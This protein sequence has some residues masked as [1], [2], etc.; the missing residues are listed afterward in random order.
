MDA[1]RPGLRS[2]RDELARRVVERR[3]APGELPELYTAAADGWLSERFNEAVGGKPGGYALVAVGGYGRGELCP[4]SDLDLVLLHQRKRHVKEVADK[5]WYAVWDTGIRL[6]HSVRTPKESLSV[7][8]EDQRALLGLLDARV[9]AGDAGVA[10]PLLGELATWW[11]VHA[12]ELLPELAA[13]GRARHERTGELPFLLEP[14]LKETAGGLR[15]L[16]ALAL[17]ARAVPAIADIVLPAELK[18]HKDLILGARVALHSLTGGTN[19]RLSLQEQDDVAPLLGYASADDLMA[20]LSA[21]G[22]ETMWA[23][24][25]AWRHVESFIAGPLGRAGGRDLPVAEGI[26]LRDDTVALAGPD[27]SR[28]IKNGLR[29]VQLAAA[30]AAHGVPMAASALARFSGGLEPPD[31]WPDELRQSFVSLLEYGA[32]ATPVIEQLD[33]LRYWEQ[34]LPEWLPVR[35]R[36]QRNAYHRYT[37]DRHLLEAVARASLLIRTVSRPDLLL[38]ATLLH[39]IAKGRPGDHSEVGADIAATVMKRMGY[40]EDDTAV[41]C[42]LVRHHLLLAD[43]ATRRDPSDPATIATAATALQDR[44]TVQLLAALTEADSIATGPAAWSSWKAGLVA[45]LATN[46]AAALEGSGDPPRNGPTAEQLALASAGQVRVAADRDTVTVVAPNQPGLLSLAAG[47]LALNKL[48]IRSAAAF[49]DGAGMAIEVF[50]VEPAAPG[51]SADP[52]RL[53][54]DLAAACDGKLLLAARLKDLESAY[55]RTRRASSALPAEVVVQIDD[56]A[57]SEATVVEVRAPDS[58][59]LLHRLTK[60]L[61]DAGLDVISARVATMGHE[62]VDAF[63]VRS[64]VGGA[65]PSRADLATLPD[66]LAAAT[67]SSRPRR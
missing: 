42:R 52:G 34:L 65:P 66:L 50:R 37:V 46:V 44:L 31:P 41:V 39:D 47:T 11:R 40:A 53:T 28:L 24:A 19:D 51:V 48:N 22:R 14:D 6:D 5:I 8:R 21:A 45:E 32:A 43:S 12:R 54:A 15:D 26:V 4:G 9:V 62:V 3:L 61:A 60:V 36:P 35:H 59:G 30:S 23:A 57:S 38:M 64:A 49:D 56:K 2:A 17:A 1:V 63:Y 10:E 25:D 16:E 67:E 18:P 58:H 27:D 33:R 7:A 55:A 13:A 20:A 29:L